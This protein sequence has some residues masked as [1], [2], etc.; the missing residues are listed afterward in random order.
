MP[1]RKRRLGYITP[2]AEFCP[3]I[4]GTIRPAPKFLG[5]RAKQRGFLGSLPNPITPGW[6]NGRNSGIKEVA[7]R[8]SQ[9]PFTHP[10]ENFSSG[11]KFPKT[12]W[13]PFALWKEMPPRKPR[14]FPGNL[15]PVN[16]GP[17]SGTFRPKIN[18]NLPGKFGLSGKSKKSLSLARKSFSETRNPGTTTQAHWNPISFPVPLNRKRNFGFPFRSGPFPELPG[19][20]RQKAKPKFRTPKPDSGGILLTKN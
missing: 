17:G 20:N 11:P 5:G 18:R 12:K 16:P 6:E 14:N 19:V 4:H 9:D 1:P 3:E 8:F 7:P 13:L 15:A 10:L 2:G